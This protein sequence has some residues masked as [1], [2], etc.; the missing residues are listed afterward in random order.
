MF[1]ETYNHPAVQQQV[2]AFNLNFN[3]N[4]QADQMQRQLCCCFAGEQLGGSVFPLRIVV[5]V[6][7][8]WLIAAH[9]LRADE[10]VI[11]ALCLAAPLLFFVRQSWSVLV[12]QCLA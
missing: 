7:A 10:L 5:Y 3:Y 6:L 4:S 8:S 1:V 11:V 2:R 9:F 12:L